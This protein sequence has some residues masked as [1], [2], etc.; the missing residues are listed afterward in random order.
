MTREESAAIPRPQKQKA[1][2]SYPPGATV[3]HSKFGPGRV[4]RVDG[5]GADKKV[6]VDFPGYGRKKLVERFAGLERV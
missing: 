2:P 5:D 1:D 3:R 6:V 4:V